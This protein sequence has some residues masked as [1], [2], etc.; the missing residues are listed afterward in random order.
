VRR[1]TGRDR[2][3]TERGRRIPSP[4]R[5]R[6][7]QAISNCHLLQSAAQDAPGTIGHSERCS[8]PAAMHTGVRSVTANGSKGMV[9]GVR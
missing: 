9:K 3:E 2:L 7:W 6:T 4:D 8:S 5:D 1:H